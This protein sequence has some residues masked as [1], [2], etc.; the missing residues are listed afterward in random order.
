MYEE[1]GNPCGYQTTYT[2]IGNEIG[3]FYIYTDSALA[4]LAK[5]L[6]LSALAA[7]LF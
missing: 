7:L 4:G 3:L 6:G 2:W 5:G 1:W